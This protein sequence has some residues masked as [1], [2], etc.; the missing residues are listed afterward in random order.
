MGNKLSSFLREHPPAAERDFWLWPD[1]FP[2]AIAV[3]P[4]EAEWC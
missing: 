1:H 2:K 4:L 3:L